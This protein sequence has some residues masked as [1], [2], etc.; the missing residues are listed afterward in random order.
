MGLVKEVTKY[1]I[2]AYIL[3]RLSC[4]KSIEEIEQELHDMILETPSAVQ[5]VETPAA[6]R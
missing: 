6:T 5:M 2:H 1:K 3:F 4:G